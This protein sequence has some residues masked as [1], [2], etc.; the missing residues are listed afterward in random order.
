MKIGS[1]EL[2]MKVD[3]VTRRGARGAEPSCQPPTHVQRESANLHN[4]EK[5][6][7]TRGKTIHKQHNYPK[8]KEN[9]QFHTNYLIRT[10]TLEGCPYSF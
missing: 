2:E 5:T 8:K 9:K 7:K 1:V 3:G 4:P 10:R 6:Q